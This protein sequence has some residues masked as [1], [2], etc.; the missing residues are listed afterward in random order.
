MEAPAE[1]VVEVA[2]EPEAPTQSADDCTRDNIV[3]GV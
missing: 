2:P 3:L 1:P